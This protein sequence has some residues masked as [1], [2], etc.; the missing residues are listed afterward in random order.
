[1]TPFLWILVGFAMFPVCGITFALWELAIWPAIWKA[2][3]NFKSGP[4]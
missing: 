3:I 1:M 2:I 4:K